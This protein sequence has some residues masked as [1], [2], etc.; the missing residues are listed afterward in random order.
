MSHESGGGE[1]QSAYCKSIECLENSYTHY[2]KHNRIAKWRAA[3]VCRAIGIA[4]GRMIIIIYSP[5]GGTTQQ[6]R[7]SAV[8]AIAPLDD[9]LHGARCKPPRILR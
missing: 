7:L 5:E 1:V 9:N 2:T 8:A 3:H 4:D 6:K